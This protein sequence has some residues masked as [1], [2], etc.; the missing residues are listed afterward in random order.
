M[1]KC[2]VCSKKPN[3][4]VY[5]ANEDKELKFCSDEHLIFYKNEKSVP[6]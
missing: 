5:D 4:E 2:I 3:I 6:I 1:S